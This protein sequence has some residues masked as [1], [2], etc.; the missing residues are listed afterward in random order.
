MKMNTGRLA[1]VQ[2]WEL[3]NTCTGNTHQAEE[4]SLADPHCCNPAREEPRST[5]P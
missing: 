1:P 2:Y 3:S 4:R 5:L